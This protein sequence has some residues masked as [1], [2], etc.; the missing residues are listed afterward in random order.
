METNN[1]YVQFADKANT[2]AINY[3]MSM[4]TDVFLDVVNE[5]KKSD[6]TVKFL[7]EEE[8]LHTKGRRVEYV[9]KYTPLS[10]KNEALVKYYHLWEDC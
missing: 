5:M 6:Y 10:S 7:T 4:E 1:F 3:N 8:Y 2:K 9:K